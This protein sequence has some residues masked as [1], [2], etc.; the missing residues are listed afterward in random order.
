M[1]IEPLWPN[2]KYFPHQLHGIQWM[3]QRERVGTPCRDEVIRGGFQCDD[4]GLGKTIQTT[5]VICTNCLPRTL[6][7]VPMAMIETWADV[8]RRAGLLVFEIWEGEWVCRNHRTANRFLGE[9]PAVYLANFEK[10]PVRPSLFT[11]RWDRIVVDEAHKLVNPYTDIS[12][13]MRQIHAE[14]RWVLTGTPIVNSQRDM[15][16]LSAFLGIPTNPGYRWSNAMT[17]MIPIMMLHRTLDELRRR[18]EAAGGGWGVPPIPE[19][20]ECVLP[21]A[22]EKEEEFYHGV[23]MAVEKELGAKSYYG[24]LSAAH[25]FVLLLRLRQISVHPQTY[26]KA[27]GESEDWVEPSTKMRKVAEI[28]QQDGDSDGDGDRVPHKYLIFCQFHH[29]MVMFQEYLVT[30]GL[31]L[32]EAVLMYHGGM[33]AGQRREVLL[34]SKTLKQTTVMMVQLQ[35]GGVGLNLQE[36][37]RVIF[38]GPWW[39]SALMDQAMARAVRMGQQKVVKVYHLLL[40]AEKDNS[41]N[42][43]RLVRGRAEEKRMMLADLFTWCGQEA[44]EGCAMEPA[45]ADQA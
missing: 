22:T 12:Y 36:Y 5:A 8:C 30:E 18:S 15:A 20:E 17:H 34:E 33:T 28:I 13:G 26:W 21:F 24:K 27:L 40:A 6:L 19:I 45:W 14:V 23:Q 37:D 10:V 32:P 41:I 7:V 1:E 31:V 38:M 16:S 29:E 2:M 9:R 3:L 44:P 11:R 42:I 39:T 4:M 35:A 25:K 43:D